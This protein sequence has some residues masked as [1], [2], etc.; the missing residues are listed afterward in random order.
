MPDPDQGPVAY[1]ATLVADCGVQVQVPYDADCVALG[2]AGG[3]AAPLPGPN[4]EQKRSQIKA[5]E[6]ES[7][8]NC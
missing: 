7:Q 1:R 8:S 4:Q 5:R 2:P 6:P 3:R